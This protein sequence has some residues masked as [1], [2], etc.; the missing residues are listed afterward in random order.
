MSL[1]VLQTWPAGL[2]VTMSLHA[3][4]FSSSGH[5]TDTVG[6]THSGN[7]LAEGAQCVLRGIEVGVCASLKSL[8]P[9]LNTPV[10]THT[11]T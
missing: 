11:Y 7:T 9:C 3:L 8:V 6:Q 4:S 2:R 1:R 5:R 10:H